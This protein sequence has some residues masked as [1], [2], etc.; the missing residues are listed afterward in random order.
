MSKDYSAQVWFQEVER[1]GVY[2]SDVFL[3]YRNIPHLA[4][5][6]KGYS[7]RETVYLRVTINTDTFERLLQSGQMGTIRDA[8]IVN[9]DKEVLIHSG[10]REPI[11][12][13]SI[14]F[15]EEG[16]IQVG[17]VKTVSG[18]RLLTAASWLNNN[19]WLLLVA[20]DPTSEFV[21]LTHA[22]Q[23]ALFLFFSALLMVVVLTYYAANWIVR[24]IQAA[25][26]ERDM[27]Q[28]HLMQTSK[29][30][31][32]GKMAAGLAHEINNPL[33]IINQASEYGKEV[34]E[35]SRLRG[36]DLTEEQLAELR[37]VFEDIIKEDLPR[38]GHYPAAPGVCPQNGPQ[39][40]GSGHQPDSGRPHQV[41][42]QAGHQN[43]EG[44]NRPGFRSGHTADQNR[45]EPDSAGGFEPD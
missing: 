39:D 41:L 23:V 32:L 19:R 3:G 34:M 8:F 21:S 45:P 22:R 5:A 28:E 16:E 38:Q 10:D 40:R 33:A 6:I 1:Q 24:K 43:R 14:T 36:L 26:M 15:P 44:Q 2:I 37:E 25:D 17:N 27:I 31:S 4:I 9:R 30:T 7:R 11:D 12:A 13:Q 42:R 20:E 35:I 18:R 29:L